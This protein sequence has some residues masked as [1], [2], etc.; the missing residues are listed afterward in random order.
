MSCR[1]PYLLHVVKPDPD[2]DLFVATEGLEVEVVGDAL[3]TRSDGKT[4]HLAKLRDN[5]GSVCVRWV[6]IVP[7]SDVALPCR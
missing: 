7:A 1:L 3:E 4:F 6:E 5:D 2:D